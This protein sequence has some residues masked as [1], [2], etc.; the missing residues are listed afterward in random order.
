MLQFIWTF[1]RSG[2]DRSGARQQNKSNQRGF[3]RGRRSCP[4]SILLLLF[5]WFSSQPK[6]EMERERGRK[7]RDRGK[8]RPKNEERDRKREKNK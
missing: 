1:I 5:Y 8:K 3:K 4:K 2:A 7:W 6:T